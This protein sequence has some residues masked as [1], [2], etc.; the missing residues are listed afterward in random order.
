MLM[1]TTPALV[2]SVPRSSNLHLIPLSLIVTPLPQLPSEKDLASLFLPLH[3]QLRRSTFAA[4]R[5]LRPLKLCPTFPAS[6][7]ISEVL[8]PRLRSDCASH[9]SHGSESQV[10]SPAQ[11]SKIDSLHFKS[12]GRFSRL[13][14]TIITGY[15]KVLQPTDSPCSNSFLL[16]P[17]YPILPAFSSSIP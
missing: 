1:S 9:P 15:H 5:L 17:S 2:P 8:T 6:P 16:S 3:H 12:L 11:I 13:K 4:L 10:Y 14:A 7:Y